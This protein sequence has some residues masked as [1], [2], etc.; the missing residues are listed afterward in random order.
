[1]FPR[2]SLSLSDDPGPN[3]RA[4]LSFVG[5]RARGRAGPHRP[6][7]RMQGRFGGDGGRQE[8]PLSSQGYVLSLPLGLDIHGVYDNTFLCMHIPC[9]LWTCSR[10]ALGAREVGKKLGLQPRFDAGLVPRC[11]PLGLQGGEARSGQRFTYAVGRRFASARGRSAAPEGSDATGQPTEEQTG[12]RR[13]GFR[14]YTTGQKAFRFVRAADP[15]MRHGDG[16]QKRAFPGGYGTPENFI[17]A[18]VG[19]PK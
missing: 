14:V 16:L 12:G 3:L 8:N 4:V 18:H 10:G 15:R 7:R 2:F 1:M 17:E 9:W 11:A 13:S 19:A 5:Y 6:R